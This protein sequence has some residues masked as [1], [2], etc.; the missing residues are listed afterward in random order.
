MCPGLTALPGSPAQEGLGRPSGASLPASS[1][2][3][4][5]VLPGCVAIVWSTEVGLVSHHRLD[6]HLWRYILPLSI[7]VSPLRTDRMNSQRCFLLGC[8]K[9]V[10]TTSEVIKTTFNK[11]IN[12]KWVKKHIH[13]SDVVKADRNLFKYQP[14]F[15]DTWCSKVQREAWVR[16]A[17]NQVSVFCLLPVHT[18]VI[19]ANREGMTPYLPPPPPPLHRCPYP[20]RT[21]I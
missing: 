4:R 2:S 16:L 9:S 19:F 17:D 13:G 11:W 10:F 6:V 15:L 21:Q 8:E 3:R 5:L 7:W 12:I 1:S 20:T 14:E 18:L